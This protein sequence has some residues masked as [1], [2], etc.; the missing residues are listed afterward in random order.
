MAVIEAG[1]L[2]LWFTTAVHILPAT[3]ATIAWIGNRALRG[4]TLQTLTKPIMS[5]GVLIRY[6]YMCSLRT[7]SGAHYCGGALIAPGVV[8]TAA[9]CVN[10]TDPTLNM[11]TVCPRD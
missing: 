1:K 5:V 9:H 7:Q 10:F 4:T 11:P 3:A 6:P 8:M 2:R